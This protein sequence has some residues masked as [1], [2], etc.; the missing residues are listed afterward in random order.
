MNFILIYIRNINI[1]KEISISFL[2]KQLLFSL[3]SFDRKIFFFKIKKKK[4][5]V[6]KKFFFFINII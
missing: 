3:S 1:N 5:L 2:K 6:F 4:N